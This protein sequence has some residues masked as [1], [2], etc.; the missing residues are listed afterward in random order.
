MVA[1][2]TGVVQI[3]LGDGYTC[4][5]LGGGDVQCWGL[6]AFG[7]LG[8]G[9]TTDS[10][11]PVQVSGLTSGVQA[12]SGGDASVCAVLQSAQVDCWGDNTSGELG[13]GSIG[14]QSDT[15][16]LVEGG[17]FASDGASIGLGSFGTTSCALDAS[18]LAEC[19]GSNADG[20][21]GNGTTSNTGT[22]GVVKGL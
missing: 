1:G 18:E 14:G 12:I 3:A 5:L 13:N 20:E 7:E 19:W 2:L 8:D 11:S 9:G 4:A 10:K 15:P 17:A 22:P 6:N 21:A 16:G